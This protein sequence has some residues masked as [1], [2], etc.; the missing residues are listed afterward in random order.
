MKNALTEG[1]RITDDILMERCDWQPFFHPVNIADM[2]EH[3]VVL[4]TFRY[5][6]DPQDKELW[7]KRSS[8][9]FTFKDIYVFSRMP[10]LCQAAPQSS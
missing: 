7:V 2:Y 8:F 1:V 10:F 9:L 5:T 6:C 4:Q 3:Y